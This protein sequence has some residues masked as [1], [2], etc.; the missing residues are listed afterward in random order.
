[1][2]E[3][4]AQADGT[5]ASGSLVSVDER[6]GIDP[7][8][9]LPSYATATTP[10]F[11]ATDSH[12]PDRSLFALV[13]PVDLPTRRAERELLR[14]DYPRGLLPMVAAGVA[15]WPDAPDAPD[16]HQRREIVV[17]SRPQGGSLADMGGDSGRPLP[18]STI[19]HHVIP[20]IVKALQELSDRGVAHRALHPANI[21]FADT[22][23]TELVL[24]DC[25]CAPPGMNQPRLFEPIER[26]MAS[27]A[28]RGTGS[29][30]DDVYAL[31][32][33]LFTLIIGRDRLARIDENTLLATKIER[34][35]YAALC[36]RQRIP[37][38]MMDLLR[39]T[40]ADDAATRW[41]LA[42][43]G[44]WLRRQPIKHRRRRP[45]RRASTAFTFLDGHYTTPRG[46]ALALT[47]NVPAA[48]SVI[49][50]GLVES[51]LRQRVK[52][53]ALA[54]AVAKEAE[55]AGG[56]AAARADEA[57]VA[58]IA[59]TLDPAAPI[60]YKGARMMPDGF[61]PALAR[62]WLGEGD[63]Q[64]PAEIIGLEL[65]V[66]WLAVQSDETGRHGLLRRDFARLRPLLENTGPGYGL[67]R[68]LYETNPG[69]ACQSP[70]IKRFHA[71]DIAGLLNALEEAAATASDDALPMDRHIAGFIAARCE[72]G[73]DFRLATLAERQKGRM[74]AGVLG[75]L[76]DLQRRLKVAALPALSLWI[77]KHLGSVVATYHNRSAREQIEREVEAAAREGNLPELC[78]VVET[79]ARR[80][81]DER[82]FAAAQREYAALEG[83]I[84]HIT[85]QD[86]A[87]S[88]EME[89]RAQGAAAMVSL[90]SS[91]IA[92]VLVT[93][94]YLY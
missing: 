62:S 65:A 60:R 76:A 3:P 41:T 91:A 44:C 14:D 77:S 53:P 61:G 26:A 92:S 30:A 11:A 38:G 2:S 63:G 4:S 57:L 9:Q 32:V 39:G 25:L 54:N 31:G 59:M 22:N 5:Q 24:G 28:G 21:F 50:D 10:A 43:I 46:L 48:A 67:E 40:L 84:R 15:S 85:A 75:L 58:R 17:Y 71:V 82:G 8:V 64:A 33:T 42:D 45:V 80:S 86:L 87:P 93:A 83:R 23:R 66:R 47:H 52:A 36:E 56:S 34:G 88:A 16:G 20:P 90:V 94:A 55:A 29:T 37:A 7:G 81:A 12:R 68:C 72:H 51:W 73:I 69:L 6:Y 13:C 70:L 78:R 18:E 49:R 35:S 1:M 19:V 79:P 89:D 27:R 74:V